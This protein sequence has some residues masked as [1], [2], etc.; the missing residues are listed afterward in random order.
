MIP[1]HGAK[2]RLMWSRQCESLPWPPP[3]INR[4]PSKGP[5]TSDKVDWNPVREWGSNGATVTTDKTVKL[6]IAAGYKMNPSDTAGS[7]EGPT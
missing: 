4:D 2:A 3:V 5:R 6:V 1:Q 7:Q